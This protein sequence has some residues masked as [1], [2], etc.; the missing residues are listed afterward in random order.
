MTKSKNKTVNIMEKFKILMLVV[1]AGG[2]I[3]MSCSSND[4]EV[5]EAVMAEDTLSAQ[6]VEPEEP[7]HEV[8]EE[9]EMTEPEIV[10]TE[11]GSFTLQVESWRSEQ[12]AEQRVAVWKER[13]FDSAYVVQHGSDDSGELWYR[14]RIGNF[15]NQDMAELVRV[16]LAR[17]HRAESWITV[18]D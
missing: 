11:D 18:R 7:A 12:R 5:T 3:L 6:T 17:E 10:Y 1:L 15:S 2:M 4:E 16:K 8:T 13:G 14:V 9:P